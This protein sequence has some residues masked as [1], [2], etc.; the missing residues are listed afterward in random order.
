[1]EKYSKF[2]LFD[3][4]TDFPLPAIAT[5]LAINSNIPILKM[6]C[7]LKKNYKKELSPV[8]VMILRHF[9]PPEVKLWFY[10]ERICF[11]TGK[12]HQCKTCWDFTHTE[13]RYKANLICINCGTNHEGL[14]HNPLN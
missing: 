9:L 5:E 14:F 1:M 8:L 7:F 10:K 3:I 6:R 4:S 2:L 11:F 13:C 12:P